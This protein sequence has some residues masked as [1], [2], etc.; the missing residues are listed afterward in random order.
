MLASKV[1]LQQPFSALEVGRT[2]C[3]ESLAKKMMSMPDLNGVV[4]KGFAN[5]ACGSKDF[6]AWMD[7]FCRIGTAVQDKLCFCEGQGALPGESFAQQLQ[8][9]LEK[10]S[11]SVD[12]IY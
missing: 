3:A 4:V 8:R 11:R 10:D 5:H 12:I 7:K 6:L 1:G 9:Q 2:D